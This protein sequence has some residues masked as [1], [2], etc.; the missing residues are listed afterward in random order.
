MSSK[1]GSCLGMLDRPPAG[2]S[3]DQ[4]GRADVKVDVNGDE[5]TSMSDL[6]MFDRAGLETQW[7]LCLGRYKDCLI[8]Q[9]GRWMFEKWHLYFVQV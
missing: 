9:N 6:C 1:T 8:S 7:V 3:H 4:R 2:V 5:A